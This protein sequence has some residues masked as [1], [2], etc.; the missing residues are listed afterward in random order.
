[1]L[2]FTGA[3]LAQSF[4]Q[5]KKLSAGLSSL[6]GGLFVWFGVKLATASLN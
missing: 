1:V 6:V 3:K 2:I 5:R 4:A